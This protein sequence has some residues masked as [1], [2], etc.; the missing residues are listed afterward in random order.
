MINWLTWRWS[1]A[2]ALGVMLA[3]TAGLHAS[4]ATDGPDAKPAA[5]GA[6]PASATE[7]AADK[8]AEP[9]PS[10][11]P[12]VSVL[13]V[14]RDVAQTVR[15]FGTVRADARTAK[16]LT[17]PTQIVVT[18][19]HV[20]QGERVKR[21]QPL[22]TTEP[23]P[24]AHLAYQQALSAARLARREVDR[25]VAQRADSL[26]TES[27]VDVAQKALAD[28]NAGV[29]A[30]RRLGADAGSTTVVAPADG[31]IVAILVAAGD[32]PAVGTPLAQL[33]PDAERISVGIEP[34]ARRLVHVG[35]R[36]TVRSVQTADPPRTGRVAAVG[37]ALD[38]ETRLVNVAVRLDPGAG[39]A[40][41][42]GL[43]VDV[44]I[45]VAKVRAFSLPR[46][47][48]LR[49]DSETYVYE[50]HDGKARR[51]PVGIVADEG[52]RIGVT[53]DLST[54]RRVV[55]TG[56]YQLEDGVVVEESRP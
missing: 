23:D 42:S 44:V 56:A 1:L 51:V 18:A 32:R 49:D 36:V 37:A 50:V 2:V 43:A 11:Y 39:E 4:R 26:A 10:S 5:G 46:A 38:P 13:P 7:P 40:L 20:I 29:E 14:E 31:V 6:A 47:A 52:A 25:L 48:V 35:D 16:T 41:L 28:A 12:I 45:E 33:A 21:G 27:Q 55:T 24:A 17:S 30:A 53:G 54:E 22:F 8:A 3:L 9:G 19:V 34:G 15:G